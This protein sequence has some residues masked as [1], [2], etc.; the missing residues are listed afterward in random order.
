MTTNIF[1]T[2]F[3]KNS[4]MVSTLMDV[5]NQNFVYGHTKEGTV[6]EGIQLMYPY[7][8]AAGMWCTSEDLA[9]LLVEVYQLN[10][11]IGELLKAIV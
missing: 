2:L 9:Q 6:I 3:M 5:V 8:A 7:P 1:K 4:W 10:G 11:F